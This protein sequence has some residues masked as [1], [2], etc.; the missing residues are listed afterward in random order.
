MLSKL[1]RTDQSW[2]GYEAEGVAHRAII[3]DGTGATEV[4]IVA[5]SKTAVKRALRA[6]N[7]PTKHLGFVKISTK[8]I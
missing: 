8:R 5:H 1:K 7:K 6:M 4:L 2:S 3:N